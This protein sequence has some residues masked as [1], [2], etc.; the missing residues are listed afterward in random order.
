MLR[1][2][3]GFSNVLILIL[4]GFLLLTAGTYVYFMNESKQE[5]K[6]TNTQQLPEVDDDG[7]TTI[8]GTL[9]RISPDCG[10]EL[11]I[12]A[13]GNPAQSDESVACDA[14]T[15]VTVNNIKIQTASGG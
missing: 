3:A 13:N 5:S 15:F 7:I 12:D 4:L 14:G 6:T 9:A 2:Q 11:Y 1:K 10:P 8:G